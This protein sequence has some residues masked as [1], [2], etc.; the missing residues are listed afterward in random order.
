MQVPSG[1]A[2]GRN[3][4]AANLNKKKRKAVDKKA[5]GREG[6]EGEERWVGRGRQR[7]VRCDNEDNE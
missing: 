4:E 3:R 1:G 7:W 6:W 5:E 2:A